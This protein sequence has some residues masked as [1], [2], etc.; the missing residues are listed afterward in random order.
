M[1]V[2][3]NFDGIGQTIFAHDSLSMSKIDLKFQQLVCF[4][5]F[6]FRQ[7]IQAPAVVPKISNLKVIEHEI[8]QVSEIN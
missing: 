1:T 4:I 8:V 2:S 7:M 5:D 6:F 3:V